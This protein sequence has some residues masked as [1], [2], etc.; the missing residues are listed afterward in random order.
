MR[1]EGSARAGSKRDI[2]PKPTQ[3]VCAGVREANGWG[4]GKSIGSKEEVRKKRESYEF[5]QFQV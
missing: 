3:G 5:G 2:L 1:V 4:M